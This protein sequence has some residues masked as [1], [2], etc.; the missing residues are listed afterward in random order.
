MNEQIDCPY[1]F[2]LKTLSMDIAQVHLNSDELMKLEK[3]NDSNTAFNNAIFIPVTPM[4][5]YK[6]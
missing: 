6:E 5:Y 3:E 2:F 4:I 1:I